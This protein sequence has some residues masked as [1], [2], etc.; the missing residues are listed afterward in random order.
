M[1]S[2]M[3]LICPYHLRFF[4]LQVSLLEV[5][6]TSHCKTCFC[7]LCSFISWNLHFMHI[8]IIHYAIII[9]HYVHTDANNIVYY[10]VYKD[11]GSYSLDAQCTFIVVKDFSVILFNHNFFYCI[12]YS[13]HLT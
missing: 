11:D 13:G 7:P 9:I 3:F 4:V 12:T 1:L 2:M 10:S 5:T 6:E 8:I